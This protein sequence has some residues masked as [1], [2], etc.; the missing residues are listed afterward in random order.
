MTPL[1]PPPSRRRAPAVRQQSKSEM[2]KLQD[3]LQAL[4][5]ANASLLVC[6][7]CGK[8]GDHWTNKCPYKDL[9]A[10]KGMTLVR[11]RCDAR[12]CA[13]AWVLSQRGGGA[14]AR[15]SDEKE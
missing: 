13:P 4:G 3:P 11:E 8:R 2:E 1:S 15:E 5:S 7:I 10:S 6:R 14:P 9:A 12:V